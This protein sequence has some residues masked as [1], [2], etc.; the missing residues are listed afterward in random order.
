VVCNWQAPAARPFYT[1]TP[2][3]P[4]RV[5]LRRRFRTE[6]RRL[7]DISDETLDGSTASVAG[8]DFLLE[9]LERSRESHMRDIVAT[10]QAD[11]S[12]VARLKGDLRMAEVVARAAEIASAAHPEELYALLEGE[13]VRVREREVNE[14]L[15]QVR[16]EH[17]LTELARERF[18]MAVLRRFYEDYNRVHLDLAVQDYNAIEGSLKARGFLNKWLDRVWPAVK[19]D[20]LVRALLTQTP[21]LE[22]AAEGI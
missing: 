14:L 12:G 4:Q 9:E 7:V 15:E 5:T 11:Q 22:E 6:G 1:A 3:D 18:R 16:E 13:F 8:G 21:R 10:I 20:E 19:P 17:G 2:A